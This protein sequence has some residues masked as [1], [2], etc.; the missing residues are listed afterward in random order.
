MGDLALTT[1][2]REVLE[3]VRRLNDLRIG[4]ELTF[5]AR[6]VIEREFVETRKSSV[7]A[8]HGIVAAHE[9]YWLTDLGKQALE[10]HE[11]GA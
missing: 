8:A 2:E 3:H 6:S 9:G 1:F 4:A 5:T 7:E 11:N 10:A